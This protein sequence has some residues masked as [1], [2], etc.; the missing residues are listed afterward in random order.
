MLRKNREYIIRNSGLTLTKIGT[1]DPVPAEILPLFVYGT[2]Q[3]GFT[4]YYGIEDKVVKYNPDAYI[5]GFKMYTA[6]YPIAV[7]TVNIDDIIWGT[8]LYLSD[9][10]ETL[11]Y[12]DRIELPAGYYRESRV[13]HCPDKLAH[14]WVYIH[15]YC[16]VFREGP[17]S[18]DY[19]DFVLD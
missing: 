5:K 10:E 15:D 11:K 14:A 8:L 17:T 19:L 18:G 3:P 1:I 13:V 16:D 9:K 6:G 12:T 4:F 2:L 7:P